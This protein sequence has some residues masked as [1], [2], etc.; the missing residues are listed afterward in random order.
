M[1]IVQGRRGYSRSRGIDGSR[2]SAHHRSYRFVSFRLVSSHTLILTG[3]PR[4]ETYGDRDAGKPRESRSYLD[5][6]VL[7]PSQYILNFKTSK[8][9]NEQTSHT[10]EEKKSSTG[11]VLAGHSWVPSLGGL[12]YQGLT[13]TYTTAMEIF[14]PT[15]TSSEGAGG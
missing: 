15:I 4:F 9:A 5:M 11:G 12:T 2:D 3:F 14:S 1:I 8:R 10:P 6:L 13:D 7:E